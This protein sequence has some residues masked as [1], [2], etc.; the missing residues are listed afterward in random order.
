VSHTLVDVAEVG[1]LTQRHEY[2]LQ[3]GNS[4]AALVIQ[5]RNTK[6]AWYNE[7]HPS[8]PLT[9]Q[10]AGNYRAGQTVNLGDMIA[11]VHRLCRYTVRQTDGAA[12]FKPG[13]VHYGF[14]AETG[15]N[16]VLVRWNQ[17]EIK[18]YQSAPVLI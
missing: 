13:D 16:S 9:P 11:T 10:V 14:T 1:L 12:E 6:M 7:I 17:N 15:S 5:S 18:F 4:N 3:D 8:V 2:S